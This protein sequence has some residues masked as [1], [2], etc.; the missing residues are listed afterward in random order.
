MWQ[1]G[2]IRAQRCGIS[3]SMLMT[4][5]VS[6]EE[7]VAWLGQFEGHDEA[8]ARRLLERVHY[9]TADDFQDDL[10]DLILNRV[11]RSGEPI[12]LYAER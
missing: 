1:A 8:T 11:G 10:T 5:D 4:L 9:V 6:T 12:A 2:I 3:H 7:A